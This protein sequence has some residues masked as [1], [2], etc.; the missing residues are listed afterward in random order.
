MFYCLF[1]W[2]QTPLHMSA[3]KGHEDVVELLLQ[4]S[5]V[6]FDARNEVRIRVHYGNILS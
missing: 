3:E 2:E 5:N 1:Q 4:Q 6:D